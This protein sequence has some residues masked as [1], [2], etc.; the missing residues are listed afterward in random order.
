MTFGHILLHR[1]RYLFVVVSIRV[2][3]TLAGLEVIAI[4]NEPTAAA[5]AFGFGKGKTA[6]VLVFD[7]GGGTFDVSVLKI[8]HDKF[9]TLAHGGD[10]HLGGQDFDAL[11]LNYVLEVRAPVLC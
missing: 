7:L 1:L 10:T 2:P 11:L 8:Q 4:I 5:M 9:D 6:T 3:G